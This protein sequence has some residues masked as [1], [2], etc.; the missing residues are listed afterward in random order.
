VNH[1]TVEYCVWLGVA[2]L[3]FIWANIDLWRR[4]RA[5][6][7]IQQDRSAGKGAYVP[8]GAAKMANSFTTP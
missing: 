2:V 4:G 5:L 1:Q 6:T 7:Q 8:P 3:G